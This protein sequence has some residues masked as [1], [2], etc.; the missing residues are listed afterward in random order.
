[1]DAKLSLGRWVKQRRKA[2]DLTQYELAQCVG[3]ALSLI[4]KIEQG[5]R[6]PS[7]QMAELLTH[8]LE[9][10]PSERDAFL[11]LARRR[12]TPAP[13]T[14]TVTSS[15]R[16]P[17]QNLPS[18]LTSLIGREWEVT[19][20]CARLLEDN[21]RLLTVTGPPGIG[22]TRLSLQ[23]AAQ[24]SDSFADSVCF[25]VLAPLAEARFVP[26][27]IGRA[28]GVEDMGGQPLME[29]L[30]AHLR[31]L[32]SLLVLDNFE[33]VLP[34]APLV[35]ELLEAA[36]HLK[37]LV[38]SR[39]TLQVYGEHE[40]VVPSLA[41]P[42]LNGLPPPDQLRRYAAVELF[43]QRARAV[44]H[45]FL[46]SEANAHLVAELC[47]RLDGL[48]L[49]IELVAARSKVLPPLALLEQFRDAL[50]KPLNLVTG[51]L[52]LPA[53]HR[54]LRNAI[55]WSYDLLAR[56]EQAVFRSLGVFAGG[57]TV[58]AVQ[59]VIREQFGVSRELSAASAGHRSLVPTPWL[60]QTLHSL[61]NQS[62][63]IQQQEPNGEPRFTLLELIR[64]YAL[65]QLEQCGE[66][67]TASRAHALHF[68]HLADTIVTTCRQQGSKAPLYGL[69]LE[70]DNLRAALHWSAENDAEIE[71]RLLALLI[72]FWCA[73][74]RHQSEG[75]HWLE[76]ALPR[77]KL[78]WT[79]R[80]A[81][82]L[83]ALGFI[84]WQQGD[85]ALA[86]TRLEEA[87]AFNRQLQDRRRLG[88]ALQ[89]LALTLYSR[90]DHAAARPP[91]EECVAICRA[92]GE[93]E[94]LA[95]ALSALGNVLCS[96]GDY[97]AARRQH[98]ECLA[99]YRQLDDTWGI[100]L[101]L[102]GLSEV[103]FA[104][105]DD[106]SARA[107]LEEALHNYREL[108][109]TW[110][111][112]QTLL[113]LGKALWR[114]GDKAPATALWEESVQLSREVG[115]KEYLSGALLMLGWAAQ[116]RGDQQRARE[117]FA[118]SFALYQD[119]G[120]K[121]GMAYALSALAGLLEQAEQAAK[122][123][124]AAATVLA[125]A[126]APNDQIERG[127]HENAA[128]AVRTRLD[129]SIFAAAW[130]EGQGMSLEQAAT[131]AL[132]ATQSLSEE[133]NMPPSE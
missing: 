22:K 122:V 101:G 85:F 60:L 133:A 45:D 8:H 27:A 82:I 129:E 46:L 118:K 42:D 79:P 56:T 99:I 37:I 14:L 21:V 48:P 67:E 109:E 91:A 117:L 49:A 36:P 71:F 11:H 26:A 126:R 16:H 87:V 12:P 23:V 93:P 47:V 17:I 116:E 54:T 39:A 88:G 6:L 86:Q 73:I 125:T 18:P 96:N 119:T 44:Q 68:E 28:L 108:G 52:R 55:A 4:Q 31:P 131:Y 35:V 38:T 123:L 34:A 30:K 9:L 104:Q 95:Q 103:S 51:A 41:L 29:R 69:E 66:A 90:G 15:G 120:H 130:A 76:A 92:L 33:H 78:E 24:L 111:V 89:F 121:T 57:C 64:E 83:N 75:R 10:D 2:L 110:F 61:V 115:A 5:A 7:R 58:A 25:V 112:A 63:V 100:S 114:Q 128:A 62:L 70:L 105:G 20:L 53:R 98:E 124:G 72:E 106:A 94:P 77:I 81:D 74:P 84:T 59:A 19:T 40:F 1:M 132:A 3:C 43:V 13:P 80:Y 50:A 107:Y 65:D 113:I 32:S 127:Q 97:A 102:L